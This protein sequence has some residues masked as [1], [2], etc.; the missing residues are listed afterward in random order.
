MAIFR[1]QNKNIDFLMILACLC[2]FNKTWH[3]DITDL[4]TLL[5]QINLFVFKSTQCIFKSTLRLA[6]NYK[7]IFLVPQIDIARVIR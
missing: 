5:R 4:D 1:S 2:C 3:G 6:R 7:H